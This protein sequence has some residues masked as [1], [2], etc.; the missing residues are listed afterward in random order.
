MI[1]EFQTLLATIATAARSTQARRIAAVI[2]TLMLLY[3]VLG[4]TLGAAVG[5][6]PLATGGTT[7][8]GE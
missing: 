7:W 5:H 8:V 6:D 4:L 3:L 2:V 1:A